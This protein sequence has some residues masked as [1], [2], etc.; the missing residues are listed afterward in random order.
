MMTDQLHVRTHVARDLLQSAAL[1]KHDH[2][3]VWEYVSNGLQYVDENVKAEVKVRLDNRKK[4]IVV[5]DNGRGMDWGDLQNFFVM[6][7]ENLDR[8]RGRPGRGMFGTGKSAAFGIAE[9]LTLTTVRAGMRST[10]SLTRS[11]IQAASGEDPIPVEVIERDIQVDAPNGTTIEID[12]IHLRRIDQTK[13]IKFLERHLAHWRGGAVWVNNHLCRYEEPTALRAETLRPPAAL[14]DRLGECTL[15]LKVAAAPLSEDQ[16]GVAIYSNGVWHESTLAGSE[17]KEMSSYIWGDIDVPAL[18]MDDSP[19]APFDLS[20]SMKLNI[21]NKVVE[22]L[23]SFIGQSVEALR[24]RLVEEERRRRATEE[25]QRLA[26]AA[27]EI[28]KVIN[29]DFSE[30]RERVSRVRARS[31]GRSDLGAYEDGG[32]SEPDDLL[33]GMDEPAEV[34]S[35]GGSPGS[36]GDRLASTEGDRQHEPEVA[37]S[38]DTL[39]KQGRAAGG[40]GPGRRPRGGFS[41]E[42][43]HIGREE[44]RAKYESQA[45][46]IYVNLDHPLLAAALGTG[47]TDDPIFRRLAYEVAFS[48]Y[49]IALA[50]E[51]AK[52]DEFLDFDS[53]LKEIREAINRISR[54]AARLYESR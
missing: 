44:Y 32:D 46:T 37:A 47:S 1:F 50:S 21:E 16:R 9:K 23:F 42:F 7:G 53:P 51:L 3:V 40:D 20:R 18:D 36:L 22:T 13:V 25:A 38:D 2:L 48:E 30:F 41:V 17:G 19:I 12:G 10:V 35:P 33:F 8:L 29:D 45:R 39:P 52:K 6:H 54:R 26:K 28:S 5:Q 24:K 15:T 49:A 43:R 14:S 11:D 4:R 27:Q 31:S 34:L